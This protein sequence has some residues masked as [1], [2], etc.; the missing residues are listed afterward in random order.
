MGRKLPEGQFGTKKCKPGWIR[1]FRCKLGSLPKAPACRSSCSSTWGRS[2]TAGTALSPELHLLPPLPL[3]AR[4]GASC[5]CVRGLSAIR[6][7]LPA[8]QRRAMRAGVA[9]RPCVEQTGVGGGTVERAGMGTA[10]S[11]GTEGAELLVQEEGCE[12]EE[13]ERR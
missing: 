4:H 1:P 6:A 5:R 3:P 10:L 8:E 9:L 13:E 11:K 7:S 12:E 2:R